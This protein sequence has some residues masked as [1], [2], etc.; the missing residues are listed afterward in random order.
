MPGSQPPAH[1]QTIARECLAVRVRLLNRVVTNVYD[2][3]LRPLGIKVSQVNILVAVGMMGVARPTELGEALCLDASTLSRNLARM[4]A[5]DWIEDADSDDA[6]EQP[7]RLTAAG[8]KVLE[9]VKP[10]WDDAQRQVRK[11]L[12]AD[13]AE[14]L[15]EIARKLSSVPEAR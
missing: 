9:R 14:K 11:L 2:E 8:K 12:G 10:G 7:V 13:L 3:A 15:G 4:R 5:Q 6:R 1:L